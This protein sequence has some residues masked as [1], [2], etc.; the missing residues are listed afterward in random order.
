MHETSRFYHAWVAR[1]KNG[2][3][4]LFDTKPVR[5]KLFGRMEQVSCQA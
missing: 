1:D 5:F 3:F 4:R 2:T